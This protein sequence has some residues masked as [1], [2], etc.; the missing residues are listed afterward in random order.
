MQ[1]ETNIK[2]STA[3]KNILKAIQITGIQ[4]S[5]YVIRLCDQ[6]KIDGR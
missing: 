4:K 1:A 3:Q 5:N 2:I 6:F